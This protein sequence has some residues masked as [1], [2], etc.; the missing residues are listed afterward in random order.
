MPSLKRSQCVNF[1]NMMKQILNPTTEVEPDRV[2]YLITK[3]KRTDFIA[4]R[5]WLIEKLEDILK[6]I[7]K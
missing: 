5:A 7:E 6:K 2:R 1:V 3:V 4:D